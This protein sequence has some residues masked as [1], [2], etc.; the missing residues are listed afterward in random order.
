MDSNSE[1]VVVVVVRRRFGN[2]PTKG[3]RLAQQ[4]ETERELPQS[5]ALIQIR[6]QS[7][8]KKAKGGRRR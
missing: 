2:V 3:S 6:S 4:P 1:S 5:Q 7:L 8:P